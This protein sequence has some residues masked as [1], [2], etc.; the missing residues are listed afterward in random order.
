MEKVAILVSQ[1]LRLTMLHPALLSELRPDLVWKHAP[2]RR[3]VQDLVKVY[4][5]ES[6][7]WLLMSIY[8]CIHCK[9]FPPIF[10][11]AWKNCRLKISRQIELFLKCFLPACTVRAQSEWWVPSPTQ[12]SLRL[13]TTASLARGWTRGTSAP[14]GEDNQTHHNQNQLVCPF[15]QAVWSKNW[16]QA[17]KV[18]GGL[19]I[20][21]GGSHLRK[22]TQQDFYSKMF[23]GLVESPKERH[24]SVH[25]QAGPLMFS[26]L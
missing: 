4:F 24:A 17:T 20:K 5:V 9:P 3:P 21:V 25:A 18:R 1:V 11:H 8:L 7:D 12:E 10:V 15:Q 6:D 26:I 2:R 13:P 23:L 19:E 22:L 16:L 14:S